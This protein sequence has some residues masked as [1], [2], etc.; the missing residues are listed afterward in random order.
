MNFLFRI[1][2]TINATSLLLIIYCVKNN[3]TI[4]NYLENKEIDFQPHPLFSFLLYILAPLILTGRI[5]M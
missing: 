4:N 5:Q 3:L 2:L 1:L